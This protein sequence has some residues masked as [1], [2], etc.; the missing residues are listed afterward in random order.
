MSLPAILV[1]WGKEA[2]GNRESCAHSNAALDE[3]QAG[4]RS[5]KPR[6]YVVIT[7]FREL[8]TVELPR[9][10]ICDAAE[11][12]DV[13]L[14]VNFR[15]MHLSAALPQQICV[16]GRAFQQDLEFAADPCL[17]FA[18]A[19]LPL[20]VHQFAPPP[21]DRTRADLRVQVKCLRAF[22]VRVAKNAQPVKFHGAH[23]IAQLAEMR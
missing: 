16:F 22:F 11:I 1:W 19:D 21:L 10:R 15:R 7:R 13:E 6:D 17:L 3:M 5:G 18:L 4:K 14:A 12:V 23:K 8:A 20:H 2:G 9:L